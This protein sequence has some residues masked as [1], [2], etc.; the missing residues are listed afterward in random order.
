[1]HLPGGINMKFFVGE[2][3]IYFEREDD[4]CK[5]Q[6]S[7]AYVMSAISKEFNVVLNFDFDLDHYPSLFQAVG[8]YQFRNVRGLSIT[9][10][11]FYMISFMESLYRNACIETIDALKT[12]SHILFDPD[13]VIL[14][15][16]TDCDNDPLEVSRQAIALTYLLLEGGKY[17]ERNS[18]TAI[19]I[20]NNDKLPPEYISLLRNVT[21]VL[22]VDS[23]DFYEIL[24]QEDSKFV[25][26]TDR[27]KGLEKS[28]NFFYPE[29]MIDYSR[30]YL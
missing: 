8:Y 18:K 9:S 24:N 12:N 13:N 7:I 16:G 23:Q 28:W 11:N 4:D 15:A 3:T 1:M 29:N 5:I 20:A 10:T 27:L 19:I 6:T 25:F 26:K 17:K 21:F 22:E 14:L 30:S 2:K